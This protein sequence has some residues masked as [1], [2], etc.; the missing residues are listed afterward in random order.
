LRKVAKLLIPAGPRNFN[1]CGGK[2]LRPLLFV[3]LYFY[4]NMVASSSWDMKWCSGL[5]RGVYL[6]GIISSS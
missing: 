2:W 6:S 5:V 4:S 1:N 3:A